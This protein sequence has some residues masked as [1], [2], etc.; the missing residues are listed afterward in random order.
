M[1]INQ[2]IHKKMQTYPT[3]LTENQW[4]VIENIL[5][6]RLYYPT[7]LTSTILSLNIQSL[8]KISNCCRATGNTGL[9]QSRLTNTAGHICL[10]PAPKL[11]EGL[12]WGDGEIIG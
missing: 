9:W 3:N 1:I 6:T 4:K 10:A 8:V 11:G 12:G 5:P 7:T 2:I